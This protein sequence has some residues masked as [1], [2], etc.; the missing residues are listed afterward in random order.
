MSIRNRLLAL[1]AQASAADGALKFVWMEQSENEADAL[2][3]AG[4]AAED[5]GAG[6]AL[7]F[8]WLYAGL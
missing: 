1:E 6:R 2:R 4:Y 3:R 7:I 8:S 5:I